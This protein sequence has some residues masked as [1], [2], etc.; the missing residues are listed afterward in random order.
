MASEGFGTGHKM[1]SDVKIPSDLVQIL[2]CLSRPYSDFVAKILGVN[3]AIILSDMVYN[4]C[5]IH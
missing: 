2:H 3:I 1:N 5:V 4:S